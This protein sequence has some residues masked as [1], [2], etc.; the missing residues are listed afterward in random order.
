MTAGIVNF[1][2]TLA[3][4]ESLKFLRVNPIRVS[5]YRAQ[6]RSWNVDE[7]LK[8]A[9][10]LIKCLVEEIDYKNHKL[11][12]MQLNYEETIADIR[13]V[14]IRLTQMIDSKDRNLLELEERYRESSAAVS[15]LMNEKAMQVE[16]YT[17][18]TR[19]LKSPDAMLRN[20]I[21]CQKKNFKPL[22]KELEECKA[23]DD[24]EATTLVDEIERNNMECQENVFE[25][26]NKELQECKDQNDMERTLVD[27][28]KKNSI[29]C[30][31]KKLEQQTKELDDHKAQND[32][33][34][35]TSLDEIDRN[36]MECQKREIEH[37]TKELD[38]CQYKMESQKRE[39]EQLTKE[40]EECKVQNDRER[41]ILLHDIEKLKGT[42]Q[43]Q[44]SIE[45]SSYSNAEIDALRNDLK[46]K[47]DA[48]QYME[49][50]NH[51]LI[52]KKSMSNKELHDARKESISVLQDM[53]NCRTTL[54][55]K[56]MG[57]V[58]RKAF[59]ET[60]LLKFPNE[61]VEDVSAKLCSL[62]EESVK[63]PHWHPFKKAVV[64]GQLQ[65]ILDD[66]DEKL[67]GL[68]NEYGEVVHEAVTNAL[69]ELNEYNPSGRYPVKPAVDTVAA[70][71]AR[72][73]EVIPF[74]VTS[75]VDNI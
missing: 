14:V 10:K 60:C 31:K 71:A 24:M 40:L 74:A 57:E 13:K 42:L 23:R 63:D 17:K 69:L 32:M 61:D 27:E 46:E 56:R 29:E 1:S 75:A 34:R 72:L 26:L 8:Q 3:F 50:L 55:I 70:S 64:K 43:S 54:G 22:A 45:S 37:L 6:M 12:I 36:N 44:N 16:V 21:E 39:L 2:A 7:E 20:D 33:E 38:Q 58:D 30:Q 41:K 35:G 49:S 9:H 53:L 68:R 59:E 47:E 67:K 11:S 66:N 73:L 48:L 62:W 15:W 19:I 4:H 5:Q 18:E 25:Q 51:T 65:E 28:I 52:A